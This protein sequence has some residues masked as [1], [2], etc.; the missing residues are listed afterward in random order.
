MFNQIRIPLSLVVE[1]NAFLSVTSRSP[2]YSSN[3]LSSCIWLN[4][5][6]FQPHHRDRIFSEYPN[7]KSVLENALIEM[8]IINSY[9]NSPPEDGFNYLEEIDEK[10]HQYIHIRDS[11]NPVVSIRWYLLCK[12]SFNH[13]FSNVSQAKTLRIYIV[14]DRKDICLFDLKNDDYQTFPIREIDFYLNF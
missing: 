4:E 5:I 11:E 6:T 7:L 3:A 12:E 9:E 10:T 2:K 1:N 8:M 13:I 14:L